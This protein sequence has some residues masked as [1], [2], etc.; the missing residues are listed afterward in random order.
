LLVIDIDHF[1][2]YN[3]TYGHLA[4]DEVLRILASVFR[5]SLRRSDCAARYGGEEFVI[6]LPQIGPDGGV[7]AAERI[8]STVAEQKFAGKNKPIQ[9]TVSVG[10]ASYP[11]NGGD[12]ESIIRQADSALYQAKKLGRNRVILAGATKQTKKK[13]TSKAK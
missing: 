3:H 7:Q 12:P 4:G 8:R 10:V 9:V 2:K 5:D 11:Q 6:M 13:E 1:K